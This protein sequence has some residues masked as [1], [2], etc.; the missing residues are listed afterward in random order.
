[1]EL[2]YL[3]EMKDIFHLLHSHGKCDHCGMKSQNRSYLKLNVILFS[4]G[5]AMALPNL[6][7]IILRL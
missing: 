5:Y 6:I 3:A 2:D 1:M 4:I 7:I